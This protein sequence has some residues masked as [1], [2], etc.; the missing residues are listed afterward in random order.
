MLCG[1]CG[2]RMIASKRVESEWLGRNI[3]TVFAM[4]ECPKCLIT[5]VTTIPIWEQA[6]LYH[7]LQGDM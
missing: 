1:R 2:A 5:I 6:E 7:Y 3:P 4:R